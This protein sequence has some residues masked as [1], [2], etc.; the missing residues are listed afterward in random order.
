MRLPR[1]FFQLPLL[2]DAN[3]LQAEV[4]QLPSQA[5]T[6][7]PD[8][9]PGN[10]SA[11]LICPGG[12]ATDSLHGHM[13]PTRWLGN[14]PY[15][16]QL[17]AALGVVWSRSQLMRLAPGASVPEHAD[18]NH[19][20]HTRVRVHIPVLTWPQVRF[21]CGGE[22]V[23]MAAGEAWI[24]DNWRRHRV[25]NNATHE[26]IHLVADTTGTAAFWQLA[27]GPALPREQW[28]A[29]DWQAEHDAQ[30]LTENDQRARVMPAAEVQSLIADLCAELTAE[31]DSA[32]MR[33]RAARLELLL[34]KFVHD[35][36]QL[37]ARH[38]AEDDNLA[39]LRELARVVHDA[40]K[41]LA[42]GLVMRTNGVR[43]LHV[44]EARVLK[45][46]VFEE[47]GLQRTARK[48]RRL[49]KPVFIVAAPRSGSTLLFE[50][51]ACSS[52]FNTLGGEAHW[53]I[54]NVA[55]L[56]PGAPGVDSNRLT[57]AQA[58]PEVI[59]SIRDAAMSRLLGAAGEAPAE[60]APLLEKTPKN[61]LR[62]SFLKQVFPDA[63]FIFL[64]RDPCENLSSIMEAWRSGG[65]VTYRS[66]P[67][68]VGPWSLLLVPQWQSLRGASLAAVAARQWQAANEIALDDL[69]ALPRED[70]TAVGYRELLAAPDATVRRLCAFAGVTFDPVLAARTAGEL[71]VSRSAHTPP[72]PDKWQRNAA[73]IEHVLHELKACWDRLRAVSEV[74]IQ[75]KR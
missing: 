39:D 53:L 32:A 8:R 49:D 56:R 61:A 72:A 63:R 2:I 73:D 40:A 41:P 35:W 9:L 17:L 3:R 62:I 74:S 55:A 65:W 26:R 37:C 75:K 27:C 45:Y 20:W 4:A 15:V 36:R 52:A 59:A 43:A 29:L 66:L 67:G 42:E 47:T 14:L 50:T 69:Q 33:E 16:R 7:H 60:T 11:Q 24:F 1:P 19:H 6:A 48:D 71:P 5:W 70:W 34:K 58:S 28:R 23:H 51:L 25:E 22:T 13:L 57:A 44:L 38:V 12:V 46:L 21:H 10:S 54:E 30:P 31:P 68:W 64:W 18:I